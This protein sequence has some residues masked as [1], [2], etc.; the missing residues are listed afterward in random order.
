MIIESL[1]LN[2][3]RIRYLEDKI[4]IILRDIIGKE[5]FSGFTYDLF[6]G[7]L[8]IDI[9]KKI[10]SGK[11]KDRIIAETGFYKIIQKLPK[12]ED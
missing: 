5:G 6:K 9:T 10:I 3:I 11:K 7:I 12:N 1:K 8:T 2:Y 4:G